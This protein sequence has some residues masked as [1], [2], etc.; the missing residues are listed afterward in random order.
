MAMTSS[1]L[2]YAARFF[3]HHRTTKFP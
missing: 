3:L 1:H 2:F